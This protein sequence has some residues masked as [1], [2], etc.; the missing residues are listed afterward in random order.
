MKIRAEI[1]VTSCLF[2]KRQVY[3]KPLNFFRNPLVLDSSMMITKRVR[4]LILQVS[5]FV[6]AFLLPL[7]Q[8]FAQM[9]LLCQEELADFSREEIAH[10]EIDVDLFIQE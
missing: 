7:V 5:R 8:T 1:S 9:L 4:W 2:R 3:F 6:N 10:G